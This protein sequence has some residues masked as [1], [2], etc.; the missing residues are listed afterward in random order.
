M[1]NNAFYLLN[2]CV[3]YVCHNVG[4]CH[5]NGKRYI[6]D[7]MQ[8]YILSVLGIVIVSCLVEIV[9]PSGQTAKYIKSITAIFVIYV[10]LNLFLM[11]FR[12]LGYQ[13]VNRIKV[14]SHGKSDRMSSQ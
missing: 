12:T 5:G 8:A 11:I 6:G 9:L 13:L 7:F 2:S 3:F 4:S 1:Y 14:C 10:L